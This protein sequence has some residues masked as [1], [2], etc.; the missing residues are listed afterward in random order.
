MNQHA[1]S[2]PFIKD[3]H[4]WAVTAGLPAWPQWTVWA[5][6]KVPLLGSGVGLGLCH[7]LGLAGGP[8]TVLRGCCRGVG[9]VSECGSGRVNL[10]CFSEY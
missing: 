10:L 9:V 2:H 8:G 6:V 5:G 4:P 1:A 7:R 3:L